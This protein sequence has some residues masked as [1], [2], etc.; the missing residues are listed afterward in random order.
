MPIPRARRLLGRLPRFSGK[1]VFEMIAPLYNMQRWLHHAVHP[2]PGQ[3]LYSIQ[4]WSHPSA[5][6][7]SVYSEGEKVFQKHPDMVVEWRALP[8]VDDEHNDGFV[9]VLIAAQRFL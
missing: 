8:Q 3:Y 7:C 1:T 4:M 9:A 5:A 2:E 6:S